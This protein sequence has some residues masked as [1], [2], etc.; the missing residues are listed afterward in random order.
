MESVNA[1]FGE[2][3]ERIREQNLF[4]PD[5]V[6]YIGMVSIVLGLMAESV[7][8]LA[9]VH[10]LWIQLAN[11]VLL[12]FAFGQLGLFFHD[13]GHGQVTGSRWHRIMSI[14]LSVVLGWN[15]DWWV[16]KH[17]R[18]HAFPNQPGF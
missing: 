4:K 15:L 16:N 7:T 10:N 2:L 3:E 17:N 12:A 1:A 8:M 18:H 9:L 13:V 5:P 14:C 6:F 11:A